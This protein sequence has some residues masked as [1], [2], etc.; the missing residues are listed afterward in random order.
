MGFWN[1][2]T[3]RQKASKKERFEYVMNAVNN[4]SPDEVSTTNYEEEID[5]LKSRIAVLESSTE[6]QDLIARVE[7]LEEN[8]EP[9]GSTQNIAEEETGE[10]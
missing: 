7:E 4:L 1:N 6:L 10:L 5:S 8:L 9:T 3:A 2:L